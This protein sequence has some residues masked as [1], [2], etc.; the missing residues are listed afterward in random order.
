M[1]SSFREDALKGQH[2]VISGGAGAIGIGVTKA[3]TDHGANVTV[4]DV[5]APDAAESRL[6]EASIDSARTTYV[7]GDLTQP[8]QVKHLI[9]TA[10]K[11]FGPIH[12]A[13][14]HAG[15]VVSGSLLD[16]AERD[17]DQIMTINVKAAFLFGQAAARAMIED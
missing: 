10:R 7:R 8:T 3:L 11:K 4:N 16:F 9:E 15:I 17:W 2:I 1:P 14:C 5:I 13:L 6:R 12:T